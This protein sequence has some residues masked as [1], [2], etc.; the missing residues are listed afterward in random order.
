LAKKTD[1]PNLAVMKKI[2]TPWFE[3]INGPE[4]KDVSPL[5]QSLASDD[6]LLNEELSDESTFPF[7][8]ES[9]LEGEFSTS[10]MGNIFEDDAISLPSEES[11]YHL[12]EYFTLK[13]IHPTRKY[14]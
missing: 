6:D 7:K 10:E 9:L 11:L 2:T 8:E 1:Q 3:T 5:V 4:S 14:F 13:T 12:D